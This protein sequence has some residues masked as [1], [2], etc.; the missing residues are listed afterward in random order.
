MA[1]STCTV[2][3]RLMREL[4]RRGVRR[5]FGIPGGGSSLDVIEAAA[6]LG[7]DFVLT[8]TETAAAIMAATTGELTGT[9][10]VVLTGLGPGAASVTNGVAQAAL[11]RAPLVVITDRHPPAV[12]GFVSHQ[13]IDQARL[14]APL[15]KAS[16]TPDPAT[17]FAELVAVLDLATQQPSGPVHIE[18][19]GATAREMIGE[20]EPAPPSSP[21]AV[22]QAEIDAARALLARS[23]RPV[24]LIGL[25]AKGAAA[26]ARRLAADLACPVLSTWKAKGVI[27]DDDPRFVGLFTG[28]ALEAECVGRA[29][30]I[31]QFGLD[32]VELIPQHWRY[33]APVIELA[34]VRTEPRYVEPAASV[35]GPLE[36]IAGQ[37]LGVARRG[38]SP[39]EIHALRAD[40]RARQTMASVHGI[41][42]QAVVEAAVAAAPSGCRITVDAGAHMFPVMVHWRATEPHGVLIS[43]GLATMGFALPA[44]IA[45]ALEEPTRPVL[46][47]TGDGGLAMTLGELATAVEQ[48][49]RCVVILFNDG[50]LSLIEVKQQQRGLPARGSHSRRIDF[51]AAARAFGWASQRITS[52]AEIGSAITAAFE[53]DRPALIDVPVDPA[54]YRALLE[55]LRGR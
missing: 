47:F 49:C 16:I 43:N 2:V 36:K 41:S 1:G 18:L 15:V 6:A 14:F 7:I 13:R 51:A 32:P 52:V 10:G 23:A 19:S 26:A 29:D 53:V 22:D 17:T 54:G 35:I 34:E 33:R 12:E 21:M 40:M 55:I 3:A 11:D 25:Q 39:E 45:S 5:M 8:R 24:L 50:A 46:A 31:I 37:M 30:L 9:P 42:P 27:A 44:A 48:S 20:G 38:W 28:G 4:R